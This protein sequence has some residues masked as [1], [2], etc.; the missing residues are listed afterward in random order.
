MTTFSNDE[1][2]FEFIRQ[3]IVKRL[4]AMEVYSTH[5]S[6]EMLRDAFSDAYLARFCGYLAAEH[7]EDSRH[8]FTISYPATWWQ[9]FKLKYF[10]TWARERWPIRYETKTHSVHF[11]RKQVYPRFA[12]YFPDAAKGGREIIIKHVYDSDEDKTN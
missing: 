5:N 8:A 4:E 11:E 2:V 10:P 6:F 12:K 7:L 9:A 1:L 3:T